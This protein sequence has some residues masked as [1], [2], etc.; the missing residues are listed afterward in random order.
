[1][2]KTFLLATMA[3]VFFAA[4][5]DSTDTKVDNTAESKTETTA[6]TDDYTKNPD[7]QKGLD[8]VATNDCLTCHQPFDKVTG[9]AYA[10]VA[11]KYANAGDTIVGHLAEKIIQGGSGVWG[12]VPMTAHPDLSKADAEAMVKYVLLIKKP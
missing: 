1:M 11:E 2:K 6:A 3:A 9:P 12:E 4:C 7:Y 10:D 8:L 5:N